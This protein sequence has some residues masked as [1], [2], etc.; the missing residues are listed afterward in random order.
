MKLHYCLP[1]LTAIVCAFPVADA[2][3]GRSRLYLAGYMGL[4]LH[5]QNEYSERIT[6]TNGDLE[7]ENGHSFAGALGVRINKNLRFETE[8]AYH[9]AD[10]ANLSVNGKEEAPIAGEIKSTS[11]LVTGIYDFDISWRDIYPF[12]S[13]GLGVIWHNGEIDDTSGLTIDASGDDVGFAWTLGGGIKYDVREGMAFS[14]GYR[15]LGSTEIGFEN[16]TIDY[17]SHEIRLGIEYDLK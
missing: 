3:A 2:A 8:L 11:L 12:I 14:A 1:L 5:H 9:K 17:S 4:N 16:T 13:A 10:V 15:Y 7:L 6:S